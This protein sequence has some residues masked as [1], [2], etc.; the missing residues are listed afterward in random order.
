MYEEDVKN[1]FIVG[2][3]KHANWVWV[4][5]GEYIGHWGIIPNCAPIINCKAKVIGHVRARIVRRQ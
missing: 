1:K 5:T 3:K 4:K 2:L